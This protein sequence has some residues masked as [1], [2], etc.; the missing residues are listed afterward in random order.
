MQRLGKTPF[1]RTDKTADGDVIFLL[2]KAGY[3]PLEVVLSAAAG[4]TQ[5]VILE[6]LPKK[7]TSGNRRSGSGKKKKN[8]MA[9][10]GF[11]NPFE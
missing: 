9:E 7:R 6:A 11:V 4:G 5:D 8:K 10:D 2:K 1:E 3:K